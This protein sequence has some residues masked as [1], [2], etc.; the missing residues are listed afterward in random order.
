[1]IETMTGTGHYSYNS[2][3]KAT[4]AVTR[5]CVLALVGATMAS[6]TAGS[7]A[8]LG[9][10]A[11]NFAIGDVTSYHP[12]GLIRLAT[13]GATVGSAGTELMAGLDAA[14]GKLIT[15]TATHYVVA[16]NIETGGDGD[17][18]SVLT[19]TPYLKSA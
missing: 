9:V 7:G 12:P 19:I 15:A 4:A 5:G 16:I 6:T 1:M 18:V 10:A 17:D 3:V 8:A 2:G 11:Y 13:L 14:V